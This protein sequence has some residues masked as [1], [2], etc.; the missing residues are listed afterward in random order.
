MDIIWTDYSAIG[1]DED[2]QVYFKT[3]DNYYPQYIKIAKDSE[4]M[5]TEF[6]HELGHI[7]LAHLDKFSW[8][9]YE[10]DLRYQVKIELMASRLAKSYCKA[11]YWKEEKVIK[12]LRKYADR[13]GVEINWNKF[14]IIEWR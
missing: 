10:N 5:E 1:W 6:C 4:A 8:N 11:K 14:K 9:R 3:Q 2:K 7:L 12:V 13:A